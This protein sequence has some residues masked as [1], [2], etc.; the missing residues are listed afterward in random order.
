MKRLATALLTFAVVAM[1]WTP[2]L[3]NAQPGRRGKALTPEA[4]EA[5]TEALAG[6]DGEWAAHALYSAIITKFGE[7]Q[8]YVNIRQAESRH[9]AALER[10][11]TKYGVTLP[12]NAFA[13]KVKAP[14]S[15]LVA[16]QDGVKAEE[17]NI[18]ASETGST[19]LLNR[20]RIERMVPNTGRL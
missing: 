17:R 3:S 16:A 1:A 15:L 9:I 8:P 19:L 13:G 20:S 18:T 4:R 12:T 7:V 10:Q 14:E 11:L 6:P 5:L 2:T